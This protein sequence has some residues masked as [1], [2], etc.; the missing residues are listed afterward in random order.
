M[1]ATPPLKILF[2]AAEVAPF[3][4]VG[5]LSQVMYF[6]PKA[7]KS[8]GHDVG[9]FMPK[10]GTI[11]EGKYDIKP[12]VS[13][14]KVPTG[15]TS[16][17]THLICNVKHRKGGKHE[18][19]VYF[20]ENMEYFEQRAN[21]YGYS[22]DS[23]RF[24]LLSRG[25]LEF[26]KM[27]NWLP[28]VVHIND[29]HTG[30]LAN[31]LRISYKEDEKLQKV[32]TLFTIHNLA[33]QGAFNFRYASPLDFD[34]GQSP[35]ASFFSDK[36]PKQNGLKRGIIYG[37]IVNTVSERY[38][39]EILK[40]EYGQ[41][42]DELLKQTRAKLYGVLNGIDYDDFNPAT[43]KLIKKNFSIKT[44]KSRV[45]NKIDLQKEF[46]LPVDPS[47]P[48][49]AMSCRLSE[50]KGLELVMKVLPYLL[51]EFDLQ[52]IILGEGQNKYREF[53]S[54]LEK[55]FPE[56]VGT[57]L[58]ANWQLPRK[59]FAGGDLLLLPSKFEPAGIVIIEGMRYGAVPVV[60]A[61]GGLAD[62][63][64][65]FDIENNT[66]TGFTFREFSELSFFGAVTRALEIYRSGTMWGG[67]VKRAMQAD[68]SWDA[69]A[70][71][72]I[73]LYQRAIEYRKSTLSENPPEAFRK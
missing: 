8:R 32:A 53:F 6:L 37:D 17:V 43:D 71:K 55:E 73:D 14:L 49:L 20:L 42:L 57:H 21:V 9:I 1:A 26:I 19:T 72:Y 45:D 22:D 11:D 41:G 50:Q 12:L 60:R 31:Y 16:G 68:L 70:Q 44:L 40:P 59:I 67:I 33:H 58:M 13:Q 2:V 18:P 64:A 4:T 38:S 65:D 35:L 63:V 7:L 56:Q 30:Y 51:K 36:L 15:E 47:I 54:S 61:T 52:F 29:W 25:A 23:R 10:Y 28:D 62:I 46:D 48:I 34:D 5:G 27:L 24:N 3:A 39:R 69:S 66:G